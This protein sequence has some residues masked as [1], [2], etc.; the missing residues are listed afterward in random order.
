MN[1]QITGNHVH[2]WLNAY[3]DGELRGRKLERVQAH[4]E[5]CPE[6]Q[7][8]LAELQD[9][10]ALLGADPLPPISLAPEQFAAQVNLRLPRQAQAPSI[11]PVTSAG[12]GRWLWAILPLAMMGLIW[13]LQS[14]TWVSSL[15]N[16]IEVLGINPNAVSW[17][18]PAQNAPVN[19][20]Q[21]IALAALDL[22]VPFNAN[23]FLSLVLPLVFAGFYL[24]W[25]ALWWINQQ[26][27][28]KRFQTASS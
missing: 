9:L 25:L 5:Y 11:L 28:D 15:L 22:S 6:C 1:D 21:S 26:E 16:L 23:I 19:P 8:A 7:A 2:Q 24:V 4:L 17:L 12:S 27:E 13:F 3:H 10:S 18:L 14:V 20:V